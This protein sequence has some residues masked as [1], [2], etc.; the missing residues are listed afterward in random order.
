MYLWPKLDAVSFGRKIRCGISIKSVIVGPVR[1]LPREKYVTL[2]PML[3]T[4]KSSFN[5]DEA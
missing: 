2:W 4:V 3:I 5:A 1:Q